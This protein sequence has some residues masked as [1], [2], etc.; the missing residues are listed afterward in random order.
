MSS[1]EDVSYEGCY[2]YKEKEDNADISCFFIEV[3]AV[4]QASADVKINANE[5]EGG[6][7]CVEVSDKSSEVN[8]SADVGYGGKG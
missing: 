5:K 6:T 7:V 3:G 8:I 1:G 2:Y 4:I